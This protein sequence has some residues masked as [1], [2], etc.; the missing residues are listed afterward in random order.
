MFDKDIKTKRF[1]HLEGSHYF[2]ILVLFSI[3]N[4]LDEFLNITFTFI[5]KKLENQ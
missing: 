1:L 4:I 5:K 2:Y 3:S